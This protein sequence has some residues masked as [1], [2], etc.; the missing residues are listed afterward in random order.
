[1]KCI[2]AET[3]ENTCRKDFTPTEAVRAGERIAEALKPQ[4][5]VKQK[6]GKSEDGEAGGR[7]KKKPSPKFGEGLSSQRHAKETVR[8]V[9]ATVGMSGLTYEKAAEVVKA[10]EAEPE[11]YGK[12]AE[13]MDRTGK[14]DG[15]YRRMKNMQEAEKIVSE[16]PPIPQGPFRVIV[17]DP[18]WM[19]DARADDAS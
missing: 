10:A 15:A 9:A 17:V 3:D 18:P 12:L 13:Q 6:T 7:G 5:E 11:K 19:Y 8:Q 14:V 1:M 4:Q 2:Q 16:P